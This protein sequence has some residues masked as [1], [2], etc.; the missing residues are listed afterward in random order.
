MDNQ[1]VLIKL[2]S[3]NNHSARLRLAP[4]CRA[5]ASLY[6]ALMSCPQAQHYIQQPL[7]PDVAQRSFKIALACNQRANPIRFIFSVQLH[8]SGVAIGI[9]AINHLDVMAKHADIGRMLLPQWQRQGIGTELSAL[10]IT[11]LAQA[12]DIRTVSKKVRA[13]NLAAIMSAE[14]L[15]FVKTSEQPISTAKGWHILQCTTTC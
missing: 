13:D 11:T 15:G 8:H 10:L 14:K 12:F 3:I 5:D 7:L 4:L 6:C 2:Q 9:A 1:A